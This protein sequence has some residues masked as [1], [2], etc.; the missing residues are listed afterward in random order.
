M[1]PQKEI[2]PYKLKNK[3]FDIHE[4]QLK[5][6]RA[7]QVVQ[8]ADK[9][10]S[11]AS[12]SDFHFT[13][14]ELEAAIDELYLPESITSAFKDVLREKMLSVR[15]SGEDRYN[16]AKKTVQVCTIL[17]SHIIKPF[18]TPIYL[19]PLFKR[20]SRMKSSFA[21]RLRDAMVSKTFLSIR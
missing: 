10:F 3:T 15:L 21:R 9:F 13:E 19:C 11:S 4:T 20:T 16:A 12:E 7:R 6:I 18:L 14:D 17:P 1:N 8:E 5:A 2:V